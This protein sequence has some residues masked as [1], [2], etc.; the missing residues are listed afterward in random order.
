MEYIRK[1]WKVYRSFFVTYFKIKLIYKTDFI[2]GLMNQFLSLA[3]SLAFIGLLFTQIESLNGWSFYQM[4]FLYA[5]FRLVFEVHTFFFFGVVFLDEEYILSGRLDRF[6]VRPLNVL[7]QVYA[8]KLNMH[9][10]GDAV[11]ALA[12]LFIAARELPVNLLSLQNLLYGF[13]SIFSSVIA[14]MAIFLVVS[15][16]AFWTGR[17][18]SIFDVVWRIRDFARYPINIY[19]GAMKTFLMTLMPVA[20][21]SF[22]PTTFLLGMD[23]LR[24]QLLSLIAG[25]FFF[26]MAYQFWRVGLSRYSSTGS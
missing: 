25:P 21:A 5:Y 14:I 12:I 19:P 8:S 15:S 22:Y 20:F 13:T 24:F 4:V 2:L 18:R 16:M 3:T 10:L 11:A 26:L 6:K 7:Y 1:H 23:C 17:S 9:N